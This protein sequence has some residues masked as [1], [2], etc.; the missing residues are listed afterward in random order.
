MEFITKNGSI[1]YVGIGS[2]DGHCVYL[3]EVNQKK[4]APKDIDY[5]NFFL[6]MSEKYGKNKIYNDLLSIYNKA[7]NTINDNAIEY[8]QELSNTYVED[9]CDFEIWFIIIYLAIVAEENKRYAIVK[10]RIKMLALYQILK[11]NETPEY[12]SNFSKGKKSKELIK[13]C[14]EYGIKLDYEY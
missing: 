6:E 11:L 4:Y 7:S 14:D 12:A 13:I 9:K 1:I 10:K 5:F 3:K 8:I 2:F